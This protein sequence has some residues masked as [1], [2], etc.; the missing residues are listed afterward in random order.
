MAEYFRRE[1]TLQYK[2]AKKIFANPDKI[3]VKILQIHCIFW[4]RRYV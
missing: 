1:E 2:F 3:G 4:N